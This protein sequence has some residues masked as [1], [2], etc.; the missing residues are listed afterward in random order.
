MSTPIGGFRPIYLFVP[1]MVTSI[2]GAFESASGAE[3]D[4]TLNLSIAKTRV[5]QADPVRGLMPIGA[6]VFP[7]VSPASPR[8]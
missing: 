4:R 2:V 7:G 6:Q 5:G 8:V 1:L 3:G